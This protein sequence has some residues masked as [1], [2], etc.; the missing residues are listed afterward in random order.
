[1]IMGWGTGNENKSSEN[2]SRRSVNESGSSEK[3]G[4]TIEVM[5]YGEEDW[6]Q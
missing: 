1:M 5:G 2:K 3:E 6:S 4:R